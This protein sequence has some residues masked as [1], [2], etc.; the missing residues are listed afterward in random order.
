MP[1][2]LITF[3][4][5]SPNSANHWWWHL[6]A[7]VPM[8]LAVTTTCV[9]SKPENEL[10][11]DSD[12]RS[13]SPCCLVR[14]QAGTRLFWFPG[15]LWSWAVTLPHKILAVVSSVS[16]DSNIG[17]LLWTSLLNITNNIFW[18]LPLW[19]EVFESDLTVVSQC[20]SCFSF[21]YIV[22]HPKNEK[23]LK[24]Y[25]TYF[26]M[27]LYLN[28]FVFK[29]ICI[30]QEYLYL[31]TFPCIW[32]HVCKQDTYTVHRR[33]IQTVHKIYIHTVHKRHM[34]TVQRWSNRTR[35]LVLVLEYEYFLSTRTRVRRK[36][37][38]LVLEYITKVIV[39]TITSHDYIFSYEQ[40]Q[41]NI[42]GR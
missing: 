11:P 23:Y 31:N 29:S 18:S 24:K 32:P 14:L 22:R 2:K 37:I 1:V 33:H 39:L 13:I 5:T 16:W 6:T 41:A 4:A 17:I 38:V 21:T 15:W 40:L 35:V 9:C 28:T 19:I 8:A 26:P 42:L 30:P 10:T 7:G 3:T 27:Y 25:F 34:Y 12:Y 36:V 20:T